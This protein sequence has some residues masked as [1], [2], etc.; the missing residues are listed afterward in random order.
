VISVLGLQLSGKSTL[1][2]ALFTCRFTVSVGC[3]TKGFFMRLLFLEKDLS[4][5]LNIDAFVLIDTEGLGASE[6]MNDPDSENKD[7]IL[8]TFVI[9]ISNLTILN[10]LGESM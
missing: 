9:G 7:R 2:N 4:D 3:C 6:K 5:Q 1:L 10:I 8:T